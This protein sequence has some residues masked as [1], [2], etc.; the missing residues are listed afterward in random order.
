MVKVG[1]FAGSRVMATSLAVTT[2]VLNAANRICEQLVKPLP[3]QVLCG[4]RSVRDAARSLDILILPGLGVVSQGELE[5]ALA[6]DDGK[7]AIE[8][9]RMTGG[10]VASSCASSFLVAESGVLDGRRATTSWFL[11]PLFAQRYPAVQLDADAVVVED[12]PVITGGAAM[13]QMDVMLRLIARFAGEDVARLCARYLLADERRSQAGYVTMGAFT[14]AD[15]SLV[16]AEAW[17][18]DNLARG[19]VTV[20]EIAGICGLHPKTFSRRLRGAT[21]LAPSRFVQ[22]V[23]LEVATDLLRDT[24]LSVEAIAAQVGYAD[25]STLRRIVR[26]ELGLTATDI[27]A[28]S[29]FAA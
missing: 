24:Q 16:R 2:D 12:G 13:A 6:S 1:V 5:L 17:I 14:T 27:R 19:E 20:D 25:A 8:A 4:A 26:R 10:V 18:R 15:A 28:R 21:G 11:A 3:F 29:R 22:R 23:R 7:L 9:I